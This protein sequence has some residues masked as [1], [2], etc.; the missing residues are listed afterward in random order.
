[1]SRMIDSDFDDAKSQIAL[2][3]NIGEWLDILPKV[4]FILM[5][6]KLGCWSRVSVTPLDRWFENEFGDCVKLLKTVK[7]DLSNLKLYFS[8]ESVFTNNLQ[9]LIQALTSGMAP[10]AKSCTLSHFLGSLTDR[11]N[12]LCTKASDSSGAIHLGSV[13]DIGGFL[14]ATRQ[15]FAAHLS[16]SIEKLVMTCTLEKQKSRRSFELSGLSSQ[17]CRVKSGRLQLDEEVGVNDFPS[18]FIYWSTDPH[19]NVAKIPVYQSLSRESVLFYLDTADLSQAD[20][21]KMGVALVI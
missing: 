20:V 14:T 10:W 2:R 5:Q 4:H 19:K 21:S 12:F 9:S 8:G 3:K 13:A 18:C 17:C 11:W 1:M 16:V 15:E 6:E 7:K